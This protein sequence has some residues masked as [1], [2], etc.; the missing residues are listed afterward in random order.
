MV[1]TYTRFITSTAVQPS[2]SRN[3][4]LTLSK[5]LELLADEALEGLAVLSELLDTL[6]E[7]VESHSILE[8]LPAEL[9]LVVDVRNLSKRLLLGSYGRDVGVG[10]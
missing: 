4:R 6:V 3:R 7:L 9:G 2:Q 10:L 1:F 5:R 8:K